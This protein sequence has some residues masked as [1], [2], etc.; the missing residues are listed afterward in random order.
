MTHHEPDAT[1][2]DAALKLLTDNGYEDMAG[3]LE[4]LLGEAMKIERSH[5]LG[6]GPYERAEGRLGYANGYKPKRVKSRLG[7]LELSIPKVESTPTAK[8]PVKSG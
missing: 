4:I 7:E 3:A 8:I 2:I 5:Y 1:T 6:A